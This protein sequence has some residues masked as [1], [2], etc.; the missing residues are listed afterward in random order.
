MQNN[1]MGKK[2]DDPPKPE[3]NGWGVLYLLL[4]NLFQLSKKFFLKISSFSYPLAL[5]KYVI[6][7][8]LKL[9]KLIILLS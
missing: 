5:T 6:Y 3:A 9:S 8:S 7:S 4:F 2:A 1:Q